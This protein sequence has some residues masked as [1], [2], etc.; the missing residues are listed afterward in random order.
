MAFGGDVLRDLQALES[1]CPQLIC[2]SVVRQENEQLPSIVH[3]EHLRLHVPLN[4][5]GVLTKLLKL[6][7]LQFMIEVS[8]GV[9]PTKIVL[10]HTL[11]V[12]IWEEPQH[13]SACVKVNEVL[14]KHI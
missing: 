9:H 4:Y 8:D 3:C 11:R 12:R 10:L 6:D 13:A 2:L 14:L 5:F 1:L 7:L